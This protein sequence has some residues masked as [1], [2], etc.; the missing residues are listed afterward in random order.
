MPYKITVQ[1]S[2]STEELLIYSYGKAIG[3]TWERP[4]EE[5]DLYF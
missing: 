2:D 4:V 1:D 5:V 3:T